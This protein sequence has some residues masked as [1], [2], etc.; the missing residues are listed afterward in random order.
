[1]NIWRVIYVTAILL[2]TSFLLIFLI[3]HF[4]WKKFG[5]RRNSENFEFLSDNQEAHLINTSFTSSFS[6]VAR[7]YDGIEN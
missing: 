6:S 7:S 1:M 5:R 4:L 2:M 3:A